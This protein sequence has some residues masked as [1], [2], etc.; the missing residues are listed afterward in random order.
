M[1]NK[2]F[3]FEDDFNKD[4]GGSQFKDDGVDGDFDVVN[5]DDLDD[6]DDVGS[7]LISMDDGIE[8]E[9]KNVREEAYKGGTESGKGISGDKKGLVGL[10]QTIKNITSS[11]LENPFIK[12]VM[13]LFVLVLVIVAVTLLIYDVGGDKDENSANE[14]DTEKKGIIGFFN[15]T[16]DK[17][18]KSEEG[19][20]DVSK[21]DEHNEDTDGL[22]MGNV[23]TDKKHDYKKLSYV[24]KP[25]ETDLLIYKVFDAVYVPLNNDIYDNIYNIDK[26]DNVILKINLAM[27]G[28]DKVYY[29]L[30]DFKLKTLYSYREG[31]LGESDRENIKK[32]IRATE[33][34]LYSYEGIEPIMIG[35]K[36]KHTLGDSEVSEGEIENGYVL[37]KV[38]RDYLG[39]YILEFTNNGKEYNVIIKNDEIL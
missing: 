10:S 21:D 16:K 30:T 28:K 36:I 34:K 5:W 17:E 39:D 2:G 6:D 37:F 11:F 3:D 20:K 8:I 31:E 32:D 24:K 33:S 14:K 12:R 25:M 29:S 35:S 38:D 27:K 15:K 9:D 19:N 22:E 7:P 23:D 1:S 4:F 26:E 18:N 13:P